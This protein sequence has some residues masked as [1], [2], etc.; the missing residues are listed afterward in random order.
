[1]PDATLGELAS[2]SADAA[3]IRA[4]AGLERTLRPPSGVDL[5]SN[6]YL[7]LS[8]HPRLKQAM[9]DAVAREGAGSTGS[10]LLRGERAAF[11]DVERRFAAFKG[12]ERA[13][14]FSSGYLANLAVLTTFAEKGDVIFS[15]ERNHASL[16]DGDPAVARR[17]RDLSAQR[18]GCARAKT[19]SPR[20]SARTT[21]Q[22][23]VVTESLFSMDGD[24]APLARYAALCRA[25]G[26]A[27]DRRRGACG[28]RL[29]RARQRDDR[30]RPASIPTAA[31]RSTPPA[32]R[33]AS[34]ARS[35]PAR[36]GRSST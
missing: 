14:Y 28:R 22:P 18:P 20:H 33:S 3:A 17:P 2:S 36:R 1:M 16:I 26:A 6:D 29:R 30:G 4:T 13:L 15:D 24:V 12:A 27:L 23:F 32:R 21:T 35:S 5:S 11:A 31:S 19:A 8:T 7:G 34:A 9:V 10:R 25:T